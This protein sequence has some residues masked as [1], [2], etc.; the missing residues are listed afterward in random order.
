VPRRAAES[1]NGQLLL[2]LKEIAFS[3]ADV[4]LAHLQILFGYLRNILI[5]L[6]PGTIVKEEAHW[7]ERTFKA[8]VLGE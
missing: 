1:P 2:V 4:G 6:G 7:F 5:L 8:Q 3:F